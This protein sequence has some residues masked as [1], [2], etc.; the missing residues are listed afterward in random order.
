MH[1][2]TSKTFITITGIIVLM[3]LPVIITMNAY[4]IS[5]VSIQPSLLTVEVGT[6]FTLTVSCV[7]YQP[8]KGF[9]FNVLFNPLLLHANKVTEGNIFLGYTTLFNPGSIDNENGTIVNVYDLIVEPGNVSANGTLAS[10]SFTALSNTGTYGIHLFGV[11]ITNEDRYIPISI[12][13]GTITVVDTTNS[14]V[15]VTVHPVNASC[16]VNRPPQELSLTIAVFDDSPIDVFIGWKNHTGL[17][18]TLATYLAVKNGSY[19]VTSSGN[20]WIWGN[21]TYT[22]GVNVTDGTA[23]TNRTY[24]YTTKGSRYD[25]NN[26]NIV[27]F[28]D[29]GLVWVH[30]TSI[31]PYDGLY[32]VNQ[33]GQVNFQ[34]AGLTW[35]HRD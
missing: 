9:E 8:I 5:T 16:S 35:V 17:W 19:N 2:T 7:P 27:N 22:W 6:T 26:N 33:D 23:W 21:T 30:R 25:V 3:F 34:D 15:V 4:D 18:V 10:I 29:A 20:D 13:N 31:T 28:Q 24:S 14:S 1:A 32:D 12:T 11:G